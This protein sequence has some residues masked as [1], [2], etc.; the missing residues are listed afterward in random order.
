MLS[1]TMAP[2]FMRCSAWMPVSRDLLAGAKAWKGKQAGKRTKWCPVAHIFAKQIA[3][4]DGGQLFVAFQH[5]VGLSAF[6]SAWSADKDHASGLSETHD[7]HSVIVRASSETD[8]LLASCRLSNNVV[9]R[10]RAS[11]WPR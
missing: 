2:V 9:G 6:T 3:R 1:E 5:A 8:C 4:A 10:A 7:G 11:G